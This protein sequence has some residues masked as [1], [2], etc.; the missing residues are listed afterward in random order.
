MAKLKDKECS[1]IFRFCKKLFVQE[2]K[3]FNGIMKFAY[4]K[5]DENGE[6]VFFSPD[7]NTSERIHKALDAEFNRLI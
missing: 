3:K 5:N 4:I 1:K 7:N 6:T 2:N